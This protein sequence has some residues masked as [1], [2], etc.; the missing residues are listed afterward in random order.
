MVPRV[1]LIDDEAGIRFALRRFFERTQ[2]TVIEAADGTAAMAQLAT[3][4]TAADDGHLDL[5]VLDIHLPGIDGSEILETLH[6][7]NPALA[8]RVILTTGD[9][10]A[11]AEP[12]SMLAR[13]PHVLQK[14]FELAVLRE[15]IAA[16]GA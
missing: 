12:G 8:A 10:V 11:D 6:R 15:K 9:A 5:I 3:L 14:P 4:E 16:I 13:H 1:L 2:W 7:T